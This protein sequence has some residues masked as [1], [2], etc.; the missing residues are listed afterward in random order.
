VVEELGNLFL[1]RIQDEKA[2]AFPSKG[3]VGKVTNEGKKTDEAIN[4]LNAI[5]ALY[6]LIRNLKSKDSSI[7]DKKDLVRSFT[8]SLKDSH[9]PIK[10]G[11]NKLFRISFETKTSNQTKNQNPKGKKIISDGL[12]RKAA[13]ATQLLADT[14]EKKLAL[15]FTDDISK[16]VKNVLVATDTKLVPHTGTL[17][18]LFETLFDF[19]R[20]VKFPKKLE[21]RQVS[22]LYTLA[23]RHIVVMFT[24]FNELSSYLCSQDKTYTIQNFLELIVDKQGWKD[25]KD[26]G[27]TNAQCSA[28]LEKEVMKRI[29]ITDSEYQ[30]KPEEEPKKALVTPQL[31]KSR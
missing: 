18:E 4:A 9:N 19:K 7:D 24:A 27:A 15:R 2:I 11:F 22:D 10:L 14:L 21:T 30:L 8:D 28:R 29:N 26:L 16:S 17:G 6:R 3:R 12:N 13:S 1:E 31:A 23:S 5:N 20:T 25:C